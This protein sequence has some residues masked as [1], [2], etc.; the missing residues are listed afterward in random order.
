MIIIPSHNLS[1][2]NINRGSYLT[3]EIIFILAIVEFMA[4]T[5]LGILYLASIRIDP[6]P[7]PSRLY[8]GTLRVPA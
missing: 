2:V 8:I 5:L 6:N 3:V 7:N 4:V 1:S